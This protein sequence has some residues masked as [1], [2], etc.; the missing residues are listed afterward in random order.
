MLLDFADC[1]VVLFIASLAMYGA[2]MLPAI[3][4]LVPVEDAPPFY[5]TFLNRPPMTRDALVGEERDM[6]IQILCASNT[7]IIGAL[8]GIVA[9]QGGDWIAEKQTRDAMRA[10]SKKKAQ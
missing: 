10:D 4:M 3:Q 2:V 6:N 9:L 7:L 1:F 5:H 8:V